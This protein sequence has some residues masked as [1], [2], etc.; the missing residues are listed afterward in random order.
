MKKYYREQNAL[1]IRCVSLIEVKQDPRIYLS[2]APF[3]CV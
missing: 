1:L 3:R 2:N